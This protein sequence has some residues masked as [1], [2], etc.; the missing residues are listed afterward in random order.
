MANS[1]YAVDVYSGR[2]SNDLILEVS[3]HSVSGNSTRWA[4]TLTARKFGVTS[5]V[6]DSKPWSVNV[7][8]D[9][10]S[11]SS[12]L[13]FRNTDRIVLGS[14]VTGWKAHDGAGRLTVNFSAGHTVGSIFGGAYP[15]S[16]FAADQLPTVPYAP[17]PLDITALS[18]TSLR[19]RFQNTGGGAASTWRHQIATA[20]DF[21]AASIVQTGTSGGT[22]DVTGLTAGGRYWARARGENAFGVGAWSS[23]LSITLPLLAPALVSWTQTPDGK[24]VAAWDAPVP[25]TGLSGYRLQVARDAGFTVGVQNIELDAATRSH[26]VSGGVGG[27][28][29]H[30]RVAARST[31]GLSAYSAAL[32]LV[33]VLSAGDL[34]GWVRIGSKPAGLAWFTAEGIR[35]GTVGTSSALI[36]ETVAT[37]AA[38]VAADVMGIQRVVTGLTVGKA[39]RFEA[40]GQLT[41]AAPAVTDYR[42]RVLTESA[43]GVVTLAEASTSLGYIEFVAD[44]SSV[45]LQILA[46]EALSVPAAADEIERA[47][48]TGVK[49]LQL[50]TDYP[51]RLRETV[52]ESNLAN[53][54]DLACN[55]VGGS[56][57]VGKDGVTRFRLPGAALP[58][59]ATFTDR[60]APG[61]L[62][63][64]DVAAAYDT[65]G[66]V[67]RL[68]VTNMGVDEE[69]EKEQNDDLVV[70]DPTSIGKY[71]VRSARLDTNLWSVAPYDES[72]TNRLQ[73]LLAGASE[74]RLFVSSVRWNAQENLAAANA[75]DVGQRVLVQFNGSEQ[76][77][78]IVA[79]QH[80]ITPR[81]WIITAELRRL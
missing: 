4:W 10:W 56:W 16:S 77:S 61:A 53:H 44:A 74:P 27:R 48:F 60:P 7:E 35:R 51:V 70:T 39:Y 57:Y 54:F 71:G 25:A 28:Q 22:A 17:K 73:E 37:G 20:A 76:D 5:Y 59:S 24:M 68:D 11:G 18:A 2:P 45:T 1:G 47:A 62:H 42:L 14:G 80:E 13:D 81:R 49:L 41:A 26:T 78:Q 58:V 65:R 34:D 63:Y 66:M 12:A 19:F 29:Y 36:L 3:R 9:V 31:G 21:A 23:A 79:L 64:I 55:S 40:S 67:N 72:L 50:L 52:Y 69:R 32:Q 6:L 15:S 33:L 46:A 30:A 8:G 75:L 43:G 38:N